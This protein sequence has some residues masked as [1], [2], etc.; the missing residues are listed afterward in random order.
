[1]SPSAGHDPEGRDGRGSRKDR[2]GRDDRPSS[3]DAQAETDAQMMQHALTEARAAEIHGDVPVGAVVVCDGAVIAARHNEREL[4]GDPTA[5][6]EVLAMR[7]AAK[8]VGHW[9]LHECTLYVTL[10]PCAM[11]AG[12]IVNA[13]VARLVYGATDPKAGAVRSLFELV[14]DPRLNHRAT[15]VTGVL[16][17][18]SS[19][20]LKAFFAARR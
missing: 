5:H 4:T 19:A 8:Q 14:D 20:M 12:A 10:E 16:S 11:C 18:E 13:R 7:D 3:P 6:A 1:M 15:I 2:S 9:R 17:G